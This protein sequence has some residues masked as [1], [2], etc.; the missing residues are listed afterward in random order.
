MT[1]LAKSLNLEQRRLVIQPSGNSFVI[2]QMTEAEKQRIELAKEKPIFLRPVLGVPPRNND[3]LN[4]T[5]QLRKALD[6]ESSYAVVKARGGREPIL[7]YVDDDS[8][9]GG[10]RVTGTYTQEGPKV[11]IKAFLRRDGIT[12]ASLPE[13]NESKDDAINELLASIRIALARLN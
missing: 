12:I 9:P 6:A 8:F 1:A 13:I 4:L 10:L 11:R 2:G 5:A 3:P 7:V